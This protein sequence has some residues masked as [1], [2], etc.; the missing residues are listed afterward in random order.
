MQLYPEKQNESVHCEKVGANARDAHFEIR[1][2]NV[3]E[4]WKSL[5]V[6]RKTLEECVEDQ[7]SGVE[8]LDTKTETIEMVIYAENLDKPLSWESSMSL[9]S[10]GFPRGII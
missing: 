10:G 8:S 7:F 1:Q 9:L 2:R 6:L 5:E 3:F 4:R